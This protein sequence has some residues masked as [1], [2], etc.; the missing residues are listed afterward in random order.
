[1]CERAL[2]KR[3]KLKN[4][5]QKL[6]GQHININQILYLR[7]KKAFFYSLDLKQQT[8]LQHYNKLI[9]FNHQLM[10]AVQE[11]QGCKKTIKNTWQL[12]RLF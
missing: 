2:L 12:L 7:R 6:E 10:A 1:M 8:V 11:L 5:F 9:P 4:G 3:G